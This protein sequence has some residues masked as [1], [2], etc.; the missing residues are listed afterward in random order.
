MKFKRT[1]GGLVQVPTV[2][3]PRYHGYTPDKPV[4]IGFSRIKCQFLS[5]YPQQLDNALTAP[6]PGYIFTPQYKAGNWDGHYHFITRSGYFP[7][8]LLPVVY[9]ILNTGINPLL[10]EGEKDRRILTKLPVKVTIKTKDED[11]AFFYPG[12]VTFYLDRINLTEYLSDDGTFA[13]S[14]PLLKHWKSIEGQNE[15]ARQVLDL[16]NSLRIK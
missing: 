12:M 9:H 3:L 4:E 5:P 10:N 15:F 13:F 14:L 11:L 7:T 1:S 8:G 6:Y 2:A 16:A